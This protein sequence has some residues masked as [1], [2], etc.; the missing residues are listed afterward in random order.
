MHNRQYISSQLISGQTHGLAFP[1]NVLT[2][3]ENNTQIDHDTL[4]S[5][6]DRRGEGILSL[7]VSG[8]F[9]KTAQKLIET[10]LFNEEI[11]PN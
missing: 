10:G 6:R 2:L 8:G 3:L 4:V 9:W 7:L 5:F 1:P 11:E